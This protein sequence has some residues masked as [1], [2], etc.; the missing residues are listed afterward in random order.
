MR[1]FFIIAII[2]TLS[3]STFN[4]CDTYHSLSNATSIAKLSGNPFTQNVAKSLVKNIGNML[5]QNGVKNAGKLGL[6]TNMFS[7]LSSAQAISGFKNMLS[8]TYGIS[9]SLIEKNYNKLNTLR[10]VVGLVSTTAT[11]GINFYNS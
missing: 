7:L 1:K 8:S 5:I 9:N 3:L 2:G 10:D 6:N 4:S 11:K